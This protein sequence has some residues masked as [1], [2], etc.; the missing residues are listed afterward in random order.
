[1]AKRTAQRY[2]VAAI[3]FAIALVWTGTAFVAGFECLLVFSV[4]YLA[5]AVVQHRRA[6]K[7]RRRERAGRDHELARRTRSRTRSPSVYDDDAADTGAWP[8]LAGR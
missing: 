4:V 3:G 1:M 5:A 2:L 6:A 7:L 8:Q